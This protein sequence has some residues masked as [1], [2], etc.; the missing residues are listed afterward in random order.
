MLRK[1]AEFHPL[2]HPLPPSPAASATSSEAQHT[3]EAAAARPTP[4]STASVAASAAQQPAASVPP[5]PPQQPPQPTRAACSEDGGG[6]PTERER[7]REEG[8]AA[9]AAQPQPFRL[10]VLEDDPAVERTITRSSPLKTPLR[11]RDL[12]SRGMQGPR[13][14]AVSGGK[15]AETPAADGKRQMEAWQAVAVTNSQTQQLYAPKPQMPAGTA[16][17]EQVTTLIGGCIVRL[18]AEPTVCRGP[19][20]ASVTSTAQTVPN[21]AGAISGDTSNS[22]LWAASAAVTAAAAAPNVTNQAASLPQERLQ[23]LASQPLSPP[24]W[25]QTD[26]SICD[27]TWPCTLHACF[28]GC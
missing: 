28:T 21:T 22:R 5:T 26:V 16:E 25:L 10:E 18:P 13:A 11:E 2:S 8:V 15:A 17:P 3:A 19:G 23:Q 7:D 9:D 20:S 12:N 4:A 1:S 14:S 6:V 24:P 27:I